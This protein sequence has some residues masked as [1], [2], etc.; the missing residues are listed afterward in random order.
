MSALV[1]V[2]RNGRT[3]PGFLINMSFLFF[4]ECNVSVLGPILLRIEMSLQRL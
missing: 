3:L 2:M 4:L 1:L